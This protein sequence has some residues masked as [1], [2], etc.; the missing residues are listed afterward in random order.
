MWPTLGLSPFAGAHWSALLDGM[1]TVDT[2]LGVHPGRRRPG[3]YLASPGLAPG[4]SPA[5]RGLPATPQALR[6]IPVAQPAAA[7][8]AGGPDPDL[9][10]PPCVGPALP[11]PERASRAANGAGHAQCSSNLVSSTGLAADTET[12]GTLALPLEACLQ[13]MDDPKPDCASWCSS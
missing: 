8:G 10:R 2:P 3:L 5:L 11:A 6:G 4:A 12:L 1:D 7:V 9:V 13:M